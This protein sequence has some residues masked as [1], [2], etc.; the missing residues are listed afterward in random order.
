MTPQ[1]IRGLIAKVT[2]KPPLKQRDVLGELRQLGERLDGYLQQRPS[3]SSPSSGRLPPRRLPVE[4]C[5]PGGTISPSPLSA[6]WHQCSDERAPRVAGASAGFPAGARHRTPLW[7]RQCFPV[8]TVESAGVT[9]EPA[10][11]TAAAPHHGSLR[12]SP[13]TAAL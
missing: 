11:G 9:V 13:P 1:S 6:S 12:A 2:A 4:R 7:L 10:T 8:E 3:Q 5:Q